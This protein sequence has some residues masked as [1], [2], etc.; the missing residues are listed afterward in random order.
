MPT[1][2]GQWQPAGDT[3][4]ADAFKR[5]VTKEPKYQSAHPFRGV[6][7]VRIAGI[8]LRP[9][10]GAPAAR[11]QE[12]GRQRNHGE[13]HEGRTVVASGTLI[14]HCRR[15][16]TAE[17]RQAKAEESTTADQ[18]GQ[19]LK[20]FSYN[21]LYF[22]FNH[23]GDLTDDKVIEVLP[24]SKPV[25]AAMSP[26]MSY[27]RFEFPRIDVTID[28]DGAK[29][30]YSFHLEGYAYSSANYCGV[31]VSVSSA[32]C[33]EGDITL[34]GKRH[35]IVLLDNNSNGRFDDES[36]IAEN[37]HMAS[38]QVYPEPGDMLLID[39]KVGGA[40]F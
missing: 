7:Q 34:E 20:D 35:H 29:L 38:G 13:R 11:G 19:P 37:M 18:A 5:I 6:R 25:P 14:A 22:D 15:P 33:R 17:R 32:V 12:A 31:M 1:K 39:P 28:V 2:D 10:R 4:Q 24:D 36:K 30:D 27:T 26:A 40:G 21:R 9:G 3:S 8:R 16:G 23:N